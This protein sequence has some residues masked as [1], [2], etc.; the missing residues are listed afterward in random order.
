MPTSNDEGKLDR[1]AAATNARLLASDLCE[2]TTKKYETQKVELRRQFVQRHRIDTAAYKE[3]F[4]K[5]YPDR[6][7]IFAEIDELVN[8]HARDRMLTLGSKLD[9]EHIRLLDAN[10]PLT[11][12][13]VE[14][15][16]AEF[17]RFRDAILREEVPTV[18]GQLREMVRAMPAV[19]RMGEA[20]KLR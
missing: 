1:R 9:K 3:E 15:I 7:L 12:E 2:E 11:R 6:D 19:K 20:V 4:K 14:L 18:I 8:K 13:S 16:D 17:D 5:R 10:K